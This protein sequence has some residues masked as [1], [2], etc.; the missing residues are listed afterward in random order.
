MTAVKYTKTSEYKSF[1]S[2]CGQRNYRSITESGS[3]CGRCGAEA[4]VDYIKP[5]IEI[6]V[7]PGKSTDMGEDFEDWDMYTLR[8]RVKLVQEF[9]QL[10]DKLLART[11]ELHEH[12]DIIEDVVMRPERVKMLCEVAS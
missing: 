6:C 5:P 7:Y 4:R 10:C 9:D 11:V 1:C 8:R 2:R 12:Y 3:K